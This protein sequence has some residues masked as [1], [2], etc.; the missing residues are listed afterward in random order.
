MLREADQDMALAVINELNHMLDDKCEAHLSL[1]AKHDGKQHLKQFTAIISWSSNIRG[2]DSFR[3]TIEVESHD[4]MVL[5]S[6]VR[7]EEKL[8][9]ARAYE[10]KHFGKYSQ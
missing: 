10:F 1:I 9:K 3:V 8:H 4:D 5:K 7:A 2:Y 6:F